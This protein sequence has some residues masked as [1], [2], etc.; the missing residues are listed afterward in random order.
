MDKNIKITRFE[1]KVNLLFNKYMDH[2]KK[3]L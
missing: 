1:K 2:I 3:Y